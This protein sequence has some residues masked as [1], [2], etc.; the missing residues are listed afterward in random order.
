MKS[1][2]PGCTSCRVVE[3]K[4]TG[5]R[6]YKRPV[7]GKAIPSPLSSCSWSLKTEELE[8][9]VF[10]LGYLIIKAGTR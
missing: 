10:R 4:R 1:L 5:P 3:E 7:S 2:I 8:F 9:S 6:R